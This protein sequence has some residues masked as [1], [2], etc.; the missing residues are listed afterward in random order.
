MHSLIKQIIGLCGG[1]LLCVNAAHAQPSAQFLRLFNPANALSIQLNMTQAQWYAVAQ[2]LPPVNPANNSTCFFELSPTV[3]RYTWH[4]ADAT[5]TQAGPGGTTQAYADIGIKKRSFC[6]SRDET[7]PSIHL[8]IDKFNAANE[9]LVLTQLGT[10]HLLLGNSKQDHQLFRQCAG[11]HVFQAMQV[12]ASRCTLASLT[13][14]DGNAAPVFLGIYVLVEAVKKDFF[15]RRAGLQNIRNG[16]VYELEAFDDFNTGTFSNQLMVEWTST[17]SRDFQTAVNNLAAGTPA[18]LKDSFDV[19]AF[20]RLWATEI[21]LKHWDGHTHNRNNSYVFD[22]PHSENPIARTKFRFVPH[23]IDQI[24]NNPGQPPVV[25]KNSI[26]ANIAWQ[27]KLL[28]YHLIRTLVTMGDTVANANVTGLIDNLQPLAQQLWTGND[29][30]LGSSASL[31]ADANQVRSDMSQAIAD[32]RATFGNGIVNPSWS[33]LLYNLVGQQ[34][35]DCLSPDP[36]NASQG[37]VRHSPCSSLPARKWHL[38][39]VPDSA[40]GSYGL[41]PS[42]A[43][44][45]LRNRQSCLTPGAVDS[46]GRT[47]LRLLGCSTSSD[48]QKFYL[49]RR[50]SNNFELRSYAHEDACAHYTDS[51]LTPDNQLSVYLGSCNGNAKNKIFLRDATGLNSRCSS[52]PAEIADES[53]EITD[54]QQQLHEAGANKAGII[55]QIK[56]HMRKRQQLRNELLSLNC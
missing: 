51:V 18:S 12:P 34:H 52:I 35:Q 38:D 24:V 25:F 15:D 32:L 46:G 21:F 10:K 22:D 41:S 26:A 28:R 39:A 37:E 43:L 53:A 1:V 27:D 33:G 48:A 40:S 29:A 16:S 13:L 19:P 45:R 2:E 4:H 5:I 56:L 44:F 11:Y 14:K 7:K 23:G 42:A 55:A 20:M 49:V 9:A 31:A 3:D 54:L 17:Q 47:H 8:N 50:D 36:I 30:L 6:G